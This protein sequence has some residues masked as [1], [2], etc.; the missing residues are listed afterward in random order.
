MY[1]PY[2]HA[3]ADDPPIYLHYTSPPALGQEQE[4]PTH[5]ANYGVK[6][7]EKLQSV[8]VPCQ[9]VYPGAPEIKFETI[10]AYLIETL[11]SAKK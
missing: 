1:S 3:S 5:T 6:L 8:G 10:P 2:E 9:L 4:D 11:T 7:Q